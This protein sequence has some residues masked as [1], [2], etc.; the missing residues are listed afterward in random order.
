M[1][2]ED[3]LHKESEIESFLDANP[4]FIAVQVNHDEEWNEQVDKSKSDRHHIIE[5]YLTVHILVKPVNASNSNEQVDQYGKISDEDEVKKKAKKDPISQLLVDLGN[6]W[7][8]SSTKGKDQDS[9]H[10]HL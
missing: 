3:F 6:E 9:N 1:I 4:L 7:L 8:S 5:D 10:H 2:I